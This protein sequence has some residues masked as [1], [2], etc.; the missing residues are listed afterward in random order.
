MSHAPAPIPLTVA[1]LTFNR[2]HY[3]REAVAAILSQTYRDFE[4]LI[5]DNHSTDGTA[6]YIL[7]LNDPRIRYVRNAPGG[8]AVFNGTSASHIARGLRLIVTH[9]D[10]IME[11]DMLQKQM[12]FMDAHPEVHLVWVQTAQI[13]EASRRIAH[14]DINTFNDRV[15]APGEYIESFLVEHQWPIPSGVMIKVDRPSFMK[16][17]KY[18]YFGTA[19]SRYDLRK[20]IG[21]HDVL[22]PASVN[23][24]HAIGFIGRPL[25]RYRLHLKQDTRAID[26]SRPLISLYRK[27]LGISRRIAGHPIPEINFKAH[28]LRFTAQHVVTMTEKA[29]IPANRVKKIFGDWERL[30][31]DA[32][33][34]DDAIFAALPVSIA[35]LYLDQLKS[36]PPKIIHMPTDGQHTLASKLFKR[37]AVRLA[38]GFS[39]LSGLENKRIVVFGSVFVAALLI[40][41]ARKNGLNIVACID[42]NLNRHGRCLLGIPIYHP[43]WLSRHDD[44][45]DIVLLTSE[46]AHENFLIAF[47]RKLSG[48]NLEIL[49][50]K[51]LLQE[52]ALVADEA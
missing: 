3:L 51:D 1:L 25:L 15:F 32:T 35:M 13:D 7:S 48:K 50:W 5:L 23:A 29:S 47:V 9:D 44:E 52:A 37:W 26:I 39:V 16:E 28:I 12:D 21:S 24:R 42:S 2:L 20:N 41:D 46:K 43:D 34:T 8:D 30:H 33:L 19:I 31:N 38:S 17:A 45:V 11:A 27:L 10:D 40:L 49:S 18:F 4:F 22:S 6:Q 14:G 36:L